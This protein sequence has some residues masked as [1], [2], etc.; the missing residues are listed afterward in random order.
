VTQ[1]LYIT[2]G[3]SFVYGLIFGF[4]AMSIWRRLSEILKKLDNLSNQAISAEK[5]LRSLAAGRNE[6]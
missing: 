6:R 3:Q 5:V 1:N 4:V 2:I